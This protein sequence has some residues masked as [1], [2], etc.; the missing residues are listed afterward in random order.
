MKHD[1]ND[2]G[3]METRKG[4]GFRATDGE[5]KRYEHAASMAGVSTSEWIRRVLNDHCSAGETAK[6]SERQRADLLAKN[7]FLIRRVIERLAL[8]HEG[9]EWLEEAKDMARADFRYV[10]ELSDTG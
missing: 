7:I 1:T 2:H 3:T 5:W 8:A 9:D 10:E 6:T 4:R